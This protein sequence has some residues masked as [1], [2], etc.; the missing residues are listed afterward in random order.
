MR[1]L[2][3]QLEQY[4]SNIQYHAD[5]L[6]DAITVEHRSNNPK[7]DFLFCN[8]LQGKHIPVSC[9]KSID[10]FNK[11]AD[12]INTEF[13]NT[14]YKVLVV[15][16]AE[17]ATAIGWIVAKRIKNAVYYLQTT[18]ENIEGMKRFVDFKEEHSH[19]VEQYLY[20]IEDKIPY[21][22]YVLFIDD[23]I[24]TGNTILN[25][26]FKLTG[27]KHGVK[28]GVASICNWQTKEN[29][30]MF[31]TFGI[32]TFALITGEVN[33]INE[34]MQVDIK[35][36]T[37]HSCEISEASGVKIYSRELFKIE[38]CGREL[39]NEEYEKV[40]DRVYNNISAD[41]EKDKNAKD[42][43]IIGTEE[44]MSIPLLVGYRIEQ[45]LDVTVKFHATSR[46]SIDIM[47]EASDFDNELVNKAPLHSAYDENRQTYLYNIRKHDKVY[48]ICDR[49]MT[50]EF[51]DDIL[52]E[53]V[54][55]GNN[56]SDIKIIEIY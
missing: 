48:I 47:A 49:L 42:I 24:S 12:K 18:R 55:A 52:S 33:D 3:K 31:R 1:I 23:E 2:G 53:L 11:L 26:I 9:T 34:K 39:D 41:L 19:A 27:K 13:S 44:F 29:Q 43:E 51:L 8:K 7:R 30:D 45:E 20:C 40:I 6:N 35:D 5:G 56:I 38:R 10:M 32:D 15:G 21:Y 50:M 46:S 14:N 22:D 16:F 4:V 54:F 28:Y 37:C 25:V 17:T 36:D